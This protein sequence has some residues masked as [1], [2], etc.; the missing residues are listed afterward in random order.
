MKMI[1]NES[2]VKRSANT[3]IPKSTLDNEIQNEIMASMSN[4]Q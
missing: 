3:K 2:I 1:R 4:L